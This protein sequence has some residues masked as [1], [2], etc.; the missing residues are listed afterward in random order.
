[1]AS[2]PVFNEFVIRLPADAGE[3]AGRLVERGIVGGSAGPGARS[4]GV[5]RI[6][7]DQGGGQPAAPRRLGVAAPRRRDGL[8]F[9]D[10]DERKFAEFADSLA[11]ILEILH[12][13]RDDTGS[14]GKRS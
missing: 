6:E 9:D 4:T 7:T 13:L 10:E 8:P 11:V 12:N 2:G 1:M 3:V 14:A 5:N